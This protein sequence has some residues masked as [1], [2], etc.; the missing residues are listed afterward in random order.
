MA[1]CTAI[2]PWVQGA[3]YCVDVDGFAIAVVPTSVYTPPISGMIFQS[4]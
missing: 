1:G 3:V 2:L 4:F